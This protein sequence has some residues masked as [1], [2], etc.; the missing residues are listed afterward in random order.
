MLRLLLAWGTIVARTKYTFF[1]G[2]FIELRRPVFFFLILCSFCYFLAFSLNFTTLTKIEHFFY[3]V[4]NLAV[5]SLIFFRFRVKN[6][7]LFLVIF[8]GIIFPMIFLMFNFSKGQDKVSSIFFIVFF[9]L[10]GRIPFIIYAL[11]VT[12]FFG[13]CNSLLSS[14]NLNYISSYWALICFILIFLNKI[15]VVFLHFWLPKAH[16][17]ASGTCSIILA[18]LVLKLGT[19]GVVKYRFLIIKNFSKFN[20]FIFVIGSI[21]S[22]IFTVLIYR[23]FDLKYLV[24]CSSILHMAIIVPSVFLS[25]RISVFIRVLMMVGHG[26]VSFLLFYL[27]TVIYEKTQSRSSSSNKSDELTCKTFSMLFFLVLFFNLGVPPL[28]NFFREIGF[29]SII[30]MFSNFTLIIFSLT[31]ISRIFF[32]ILICASLLFGKK[33]LKTNLKTNGTD[34]INSIFGV[35]ILIISPLIFFSFSLKLKRYFVGVKI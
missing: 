4:F 30:A 20:R 7:I 32:T 12:F 23:F 2:Q 28:I 31:L 19:F 18:A 1:S 35:L 26:Y 11:D 6:I 25:Q 5:V 10:I 22:L 8:E 13:G 33:F 16:G 9:N 34:L 24:A 15:P 29:C 3:S 17:R 14:R 27:V 21:G